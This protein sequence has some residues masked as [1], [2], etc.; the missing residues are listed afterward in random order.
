MTGEERY[1]LEMTPETAQIVSEACELFARTVFG[2]LNMAVDVLAE[3]IPL[4]KIP[5]TDSEYHQDQFNEWVKRRS[6]AYLKA[7]EIKGLLMPEISVNGSYGVGH[8][9]EAD[10]A[11][12]AYEVLRYTMAWHDHPDGGITVNFDKPMTW[13]DEPLPKC[14]V[15]EKE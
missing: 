9:R 13:T 11:W 10:I 2:Q 4:D 5:P 15:E 3:G 7:K 1:V 14:R 12:Q 8:N 6:A